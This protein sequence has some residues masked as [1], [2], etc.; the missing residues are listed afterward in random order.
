LRKRQF[1]IFG[2]AGLALLLL[3][4]FS[5]FGWHSLKKNIG[6]ESGFWSAGARAEDWD[7]DGNWA[8]SIIAP[9]KEDPF[10]YAYAGTNVVPGTGKLTLP[11]YHAR[12]AQIASKKLS[13]GWIFKPVQWIAPGGTTDRKA[14]QRILFEQGVLKPLI[15][16]TRNKISRDPG[17]GPESLARYRSALLALI[18]FEADRYST[19]GP[20]LSDTNAATRY[21]G[22]FLSFL[23]DTSDAPVDTNLASVFA[24][25]YSRASSEQGAW[26]PPWLSG[27][28][29]LAKN[30][31]IRVGLENYRKANQSLQQ[32]IASQVTGLN[33]FAD[34]LSSYHQAESNWLSR[35]SG[36]CP[37]TKLQ[38]SLNQVVQN[39]QLLLQDTNGFRGPLTNLTAEYLRL[40][41]DAR[42]LSEDLFQ[43]IAASLPAGE[44]T[45]E[46][47]FRDIEAQLR[48]F[49]SE[50]GRQVSQSL[51][52]RSNRLA[53]IDADLLAFAGS[54]T[55]SQFEVRYGLYTQACALADA[56]A[57]VPPE[58]VGS[59]WVRFKAMRNVAEGL[60]TGLLGY[61]GAYQ[62]P[63]SNV[64]SQIA[65]NA[66]RTLQQ[67]YVSNYVAGVSRSLN[68]LTAVTIADLE[69][70]VKLLRDVTADLKAEAELGPQASQLV[71]VRSALASTK[72]RIR[73]IVEAALAR[74][75]R[76]PIVR[77][78]DPSMTVQDVRAFETQVAGVLN[79]LKDPGLA[80]VVES[81]AVL[82]VQ[83]YLEV[84]QGL[85]AEDGSAAEAEIALVMPAERGDDFT[86][87]TVFPEVRISLGS[88]GAWKWF[89][90]ELELNKR[91][92]LVVGKLDSPVKIEFR[93]SQEDPSPPP[94]L[95]SEGA[96]GMV[97]MLHLPEGQ[98]RDQGV[99]WRI[100]IPLEDA[101]QGLKGKVSFEFRLKRPLPNPADWPRK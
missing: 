81:N 36:W 6:A 9:G 98:W 10:H 2:T 65:G 47:L 45:K 39:R 35:T 77:D 66:A 5:G 58:D 44:R 14:A 31:A 30:T 46:G 15:V 101:T 82:G 61:E 32:A 64:C 57:V 84:A 7:A 34:A 83:R 17:D 48:A 85:L 67:A 97:R 72:Q 74:N 86:I 75:A 21:L 41:A 87:L 59:Q 19:N 20:Y 73:Q 1:A 18:R 99:A 88:E 79:M 91:L 96:W 90:N 55:R 69:G 71:P 13:V 100:P 92:V 29:S 50:A 11:E 42:N 54:G 63:V 27:G 3:L 23:T 53:E 76:F 37:P 60:G 16:E 43:D 70:V 80:E 25:T 93:R 28:D 22:S 94:P 68:N 40:E 62:Q 78:T 12:L 38:E 33:S 26:P 52:S 95:S 4:G 56:P 8:Y 89:G 49:E 51:E 24:W